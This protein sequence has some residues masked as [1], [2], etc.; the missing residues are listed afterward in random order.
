[1]I[2]VDTILIKIH[3]KFS[4]SFFFAFKLPILFLEH[5]DS[6]CQFAMF[7]KAKHH[8]GIEFQ[9]NVLWVFKAI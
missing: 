7:L 6:V 3:R 8:H 9:N 4:T 1:M 5:F 2:K